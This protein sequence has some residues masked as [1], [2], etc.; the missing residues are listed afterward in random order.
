MLYWVYFNGM[1]HVRNR[2]RETTEKRQKQQHT[3]YITSKITTDNFTDKYIHLQ[4]IAF[5][6]QKGLNDYI[7]KWQG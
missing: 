5:I 6:S 2:K 3:K 7:L 1:I 4:N